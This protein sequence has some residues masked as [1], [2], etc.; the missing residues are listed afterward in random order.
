MSRD[1]M[2]A[3]DSPLDLAVYATVHEYPGGAARLAALAGMNPGTLYNKA[4]PRCEQHH[5]TVAE[6]VR[7]QALTGDCRI[8]AAE[9]ELIGHLSIP[10]G[11]YDG[12]SD[13]D[14]L[15]VYAG[16]HA[17]IGR[18][19]ATLHEA[20]ADGRITAAEVVRMRAELYRD[21][22]AGAVLLK[23]LEALCDG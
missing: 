2:P 12:T 5:L 7:V 20:L 13:V 22:C 11:G 15:T 19:A 17:E 4:N 9:G 8:H 21:W 23:R 16:L 14:L 18:T 3:L 10:S 1:R 6:A